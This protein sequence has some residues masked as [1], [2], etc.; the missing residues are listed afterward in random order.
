MTSKDF[1]LIDE[2]LDKASNSVDYL[3][4][5]PESIKPK[6]IETFPEVEG[7]LGTQLI[8]NKPLNIISFPLAYGLY[9]GM[10]HDKTKEQELIDILNELIGE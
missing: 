3:I 10:T 5:F 6:I 2:W 8:F 9:V 1:L 7:L 4:E